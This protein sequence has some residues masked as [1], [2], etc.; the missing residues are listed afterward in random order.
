MAGAGVEMDKGGR[1]WTADWTA[2]MGDITRSPDT[3]KRPEGLNF[4][5][6]VTVPPSPAA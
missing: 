4:P 5:R 3:T 2:D 1:S 6:L